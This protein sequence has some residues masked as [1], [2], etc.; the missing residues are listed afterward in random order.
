MSA[1]TL[2]SIFLILAYLVIPA[3]A[4]LAAPPPIYVDQNAVGANDGSS[5]YDAYTNLQVALFA[6]VSGDQIWVAQ[7]FYQPGV[8]RTSTFQLKNGVIL[9]GGFPAGGSSLEDRDWKNYETVLSGELGAGDNDSD[10]IYH[11]VTGSGVNNTAILDGFIIW[12]GNA[13]GSGCPGTGCGGGMYNNGGSPTLRNVTFK[14]NAAVSGGGMANSNNSSPDL[15]NV[16]FLRN[17]AS[18]H[19]GGMYNQFYSMPTLVN[20]FFLG[21]S[22]AMGGG[23]ENYSNSDALLSN[24]IFSGNYASNNGGGLYN[25]ESDPTMVNTVIA[26]NQA[27][28]SGGG[29][30]NYEANLY[31][32]NSILWGNSAPSYPHIRNDSSSS[33][34]AYSL[35]Q[36]GCPVSGACSGNLFTNDP[37]FGRDP[38]P[39]EDDTWGTEDDDYGELKLEYSSEAIDAGNN[40]LVVFGVTGDLAYNP[41]FA[42]VP[43]VIDTG[44]GSPPIV[45]MGAYEAPPR[46]LYVDQSATGADNGQSWVDAFTDLQDAL[47]WARSGLGMIYVA[48]GTYKPGAKRTDT[49]EMVEGVDV[50]GGFP[51]GGGGIKDRDFDLYPSV[52]S[53]DIGVTGDEADNSYHVVDASKTAFSDRLDG[54][55]IVDGNANGDEYRFRYGGGIYNWGGSPSLRNLKIWNNK[56]D[57]GGGIHNRDGYIS[58]FNVNFKSNH[59]IRGGG[60]H[61]RASNI[62]FTDVEFYQ[63]TA[64]QDGGATLNDA[65]NLQIQKLTVDHNVAELGGGV[66]NE[67]GSEVEMNEVRFWGNQASDSGGAIY[68]HMNSSVLVISG[69]FGENWAAEDGGAIFSE[70]SDLELIGADFELNDANSGAGLYLS[71]GEADLSNAEFSL[72]FA[73]YGGGIYKTG[74]ASAFLVNVTFCANR[75]E[76]SGGGVYNNSGELTLANSILWSNYI[77]EVVITSGLVSVQDSLIGG[78]CPSG[79]SCSGGLLTTDPQ[80][81]RVPEYSLKYGADPGDLRLQATSPAIDAG[82][83]NL[84][85]PDDYDLDLDWDY[86]EKLP[87]DLDGL[88]RFIDHYILDTGIGTAPLVDMGAHE[89]LVLNYLPLVLR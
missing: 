8:N 45:D 44:N 16:T 62:I 4:T 71:E 68:N 77:S 33:I 34:V 22:A 35:V 89:T 75:G 15:E 69:V 12:N 85:P 83:N 29:V 72:N 86:L 66:F 74:E 40:D 43:S 6:S 51:P 58:L 56:A 81:V 32:Y 30:N 9:Y 1:K 37:D 59:A 73:D 17:L 70:N 14:E 11:V 28:A 88:P 13:N 38:D 48:M 80:F 47:R 5:W 31:L 79:A 41:R 87:I 10:N 67:D 24:V 76:V 63:N 53:G 25:E 50:Y 65:S 84:L 7:G 36:G 82:N 61:N 23:M 52:L 2:F 49:F 19:G 39:G 20:V 55:K 78:G 46:Y 64:S 21:N 27:G 54:F 57:Y 42:N 3:P 26:G 60:M 18:A